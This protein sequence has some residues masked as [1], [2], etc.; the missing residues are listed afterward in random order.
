MGFTDI[1]AISILL[2]EFQIELDIFSGVSNP[3]W[4][5]T[6]SDGDFSSLVSVLSQATST[7]LP[8]LVGYRGFV[9][10]AIF[11]DETKVEQRFGKGGQSTTTTEITLLN[12]NGGTL[13]ADVIT[14]ATAGINGAVSRDALKFHLLRKFSRRFKIQRFKIYSAFNPKH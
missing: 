14:I 10:T 13:S 9:V 6:S 12:S 11:S 2:P 4:T 1:R 8:L 3:T 5:V 7:S